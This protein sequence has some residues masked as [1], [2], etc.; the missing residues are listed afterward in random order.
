MA[1]AGLRSAF[2]VW[3][4]E[5]S[6]PNLTLLALSPALIGAWPKRQTPNP[7]RQTQ[8]AERSEKC[9]LDRGGPEGAG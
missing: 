6:V 3:R 7:K 9:G 4:L 8:N 5:L 1:V 2:G